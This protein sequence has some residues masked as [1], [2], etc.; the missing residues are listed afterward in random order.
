MENDHLF[1]HHTTIRLNHN[2]PQMGATL[3]AWI[4]S[5]QLGKLPLH[6]MELLWLSAGDTPHY[7]KPYTLQIIYSM[8]YRKKKNYFIF[9]FKMKKL[10]KG[11]SV[12]LPKLILRMGHY[13]INSVFMFSFL[14]LCSMFGFVMLIVWFWFSFILNKF[15][16]C[17]QNEQIVSWSEVS[18]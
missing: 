4:T 6:N 9:Q 13:W 1:T 15:T 12:T 11:S 14:L 18:L 10:L 5:I 16:V 2:F 3:Y 17:F 8:T 7:Q